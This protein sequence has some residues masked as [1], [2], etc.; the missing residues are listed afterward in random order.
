MHTNFDDD[1]IGFVFAYQSSSRFYVVSWKRNNQT[2]FGGL[3]LAGVTIKVYYFFENLLCIAM[4]R[5]AY[6]RKF[7]Q[8]PDP[9]Q[10]CRVPF[11]K[12][13]PLQMK[14]T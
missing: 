7:V 9:V 13:K 10:R 8:S 11:G 6:Y 2:L 3:G 12:Q 14:Y 4:F 1:Y 5:C